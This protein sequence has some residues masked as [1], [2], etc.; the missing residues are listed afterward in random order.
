MRSKEAS[1]CMS[2]TS[3]GI[4]LHFLIYLGQKPKEKVEGVCV[5]T[6]ENR[7]LQLWVW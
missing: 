5:Q 4:Y 3:L 2:I 6:L 1:N 7:T